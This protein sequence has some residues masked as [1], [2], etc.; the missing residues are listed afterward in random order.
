MKR[1]TPRRAAKHV[2]LVEVR[3]KSSNRRWRGRLSSCAIGLGVL[4]LVSAGS[5]F[6]T[7]AVMHG[8]FYQ[9]PDFTVRNVDIQASGGIGRREILEAARIPRDANLM[10]LNLE[11]I[12]HRIASMPYIEHA[13]V[14]RRLPGT[15]RITVAE[16][17]P[18]AR[19]M[20]FSPR[21]NQLA[22]Q[23]YYIDA[24]GFIMKP[25]PGEKLRPLPV[26]MGISHDQLVD[27]D[28]TDQQELL[29]ALN[30]L[31]M[32]DITTLRHDLDL[33]QIEIYQRGYLVLRTRD[34]GLIRFRPDHLNQ[35]I[36]RLQFILDDAR[37]RR[38]FVRTVDLTPE[39][40][41]PVTYH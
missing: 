39:R 8:V 22:Q 11:E 34:Q 36:T 3:Q 24:G 19:L 13:R 26:I 7:R 16:R 14:E 25:K 27:G 23:V 38:L 31:R 20:P 18:V 5:W 17:Q 28:R 2:L 1:R 40:N 30:L 6:G 41:V 21:G 37:S 35:Q 29:S 12:R 15:L 4:A 9:N 32:A 10:S 33:T